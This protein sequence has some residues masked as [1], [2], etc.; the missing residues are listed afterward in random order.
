[1]RTRLSLP[2]IPAGF[3]TLLLVSV[4]V[5]GDRLSQQLE[6]VP[7]CLITAETSLSLQVEIAETARQK[8]IGVMG[9]TSLPASHGMLFRYTRER[10]PDDGFWMYQTLI[11]LDIAW[12]DRNGVIVAMNTMEPC[13]QQDSRNCPVYLP[14]QPHLEVL[15]M[16]AGYF[17]NHH[18]SVG[19]TFR[20]N[21]SHPN[22]CE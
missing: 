4:P 8:R 13:Q 14:G 9:R 16:N 3:L 10:Q 20:L 21:P 6:A 17:Q 11:P 15:E 1:M 2:A 5:W 7:A 19:D 12:L 18:V 22:K